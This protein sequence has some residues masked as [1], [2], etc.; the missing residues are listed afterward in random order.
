MFWGDLEVFWR[1][2][3]AFPS[4]GLL[5]APGVGVDGEGFRLKSSLDGDRD[6]DHGVAEDDHNLGIDV[7]HMQ[8]L[9]NYQPRLSNAQIEEIQGIQHMFE[10]GPFAKIDQAALLEETLARAESKGAL[11]LDLA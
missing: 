1:I 10:H 4:S 5:F 3:H 7:P 9:N 11:V 8:A 6:R 2:K